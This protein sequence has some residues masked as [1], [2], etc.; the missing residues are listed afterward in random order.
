MA[1]LGL[2]LQRKLIFLRS[3]LCIRDFHKFDETA[4]TVVPCLNLEDVRM[5]CYKRIYIN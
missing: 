3:L 2:K 5:I 1:C 4:K